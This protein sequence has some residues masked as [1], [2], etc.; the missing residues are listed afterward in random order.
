MIEVTGDE[1]D[2]KRAGQVREASELKRRADSGDREAAKA[3]SERI[4]EL[5]QTSLHNPDPHYAY[6]MA[7][8]EKKG[9]IGQLR[10]LGY[11]VVP[12]NDKT[13]AIQGYEQDGAQTV[14]SMTLMRTKRENYEKR[15]KN[16]AL[17]YEMQTGGEI[18]KARDNINKIARDGGF[19]AQGKDITFDESHDEPEVVVDRDKS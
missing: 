14:G 19:I 2:R 15:R 17:I 12:V 5:D 11:E 7:S 8:N 16:A 6:R 1:R 18:Q 3:L 4:R 10:G 13:Q 9:R